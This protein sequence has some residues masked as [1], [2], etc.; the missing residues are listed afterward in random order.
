M[1]SDLDNRLRTPA[2]M[3]AAVAE[4]LRLKASRY[5]MIRKRQFLIRGFWPVR[6]GEDDYA[7]SNS[8]CRHVS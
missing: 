8:S 2:S 6:Y 4:A 3:A 1:I 5:T 7:G